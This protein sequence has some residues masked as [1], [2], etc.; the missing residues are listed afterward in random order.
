MA[1]QWVVYEAID[2]D[3]VAIG[4]G[5]DPKVDQKSRPVELLVRWLVHRNQS[6]KRDYRSALTEQLQSLPTPLVEWWRTRHGDL[7]EELYAAKY[8]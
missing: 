4:V 3:G 8:L 1:I 5:H 2:R 6:Y 7:S